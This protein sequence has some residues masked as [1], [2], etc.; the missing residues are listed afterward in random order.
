MVDK[1]ISYPLSK[2]HFG[3]LISRS[4]SFDVLIQNRVS[5]GPKLAKGFLALIQI[6]MR[7]LI[8]QP[9]NEWLDSLSLA[10]LHV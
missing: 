1:L 5:E 2:P 4:A 10:N 8:H 3:H 9:L 7:E 6:I